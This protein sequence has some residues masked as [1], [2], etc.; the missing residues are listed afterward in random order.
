MDL[1][2][3]L[4]HPARRTTFVLDLYYYVG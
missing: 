2:E 1:F 3:L 4:I